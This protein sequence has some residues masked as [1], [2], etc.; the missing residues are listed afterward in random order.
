MLFLIGPRQVVGLH[1]RCLVI[2]RPPSAPTYV[3]YLLIL[4]YSPLRTIRKGTI[5]Y[6]T[7]QYNGEQKQKICQ[8]INL[9]DGTTMEI[10]H[11]HQSSG[12]PVLPWFLSPATFHTFCAR[13][14]WGEVQL[15]VEVRNATVSP[16]TFI[17]IW[18]SRLKPSWSSQSLSPSLHFGDSRPITTCTLQSPLG[19]LTLAARNAWRDIRSPGPHRAILLDPHWNTPISYG[20][21]WEACAHGCKGICSLRY[22][23]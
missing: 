8:K 7:I 3:L 4:I 17:D 14:N 15:V 12:S 10:Y 16:M 5:Q 20:S 13:R 6:N 22:G 2:E 18:M 21:Y 1:H 23:E 19:A 11:L 9:P